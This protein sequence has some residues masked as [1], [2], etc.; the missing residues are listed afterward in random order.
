MCADGSP[1]VLCLICVMVPLCKITLLQKRKYPPDWKL[2]V[3]NV[4]PWPKSEKNW[5]RRNQFFNME[6]CETGFYRPLTD[7][8][9]DVFKKFLC[10]IVRELWCVKLDI[11]VQK[12]RRSQTKLRRNTPLLL[13]WLPRGTLKVFVMSQWGDVT[14]AQISIKDPWIHRI[15]VRIF[16]PL[17]GPH[18][19]FRFLTDTPPASCSGFPE[20]NSQSQLQ[21]PCTT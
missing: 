6:Y 2:L 21:I 15:R 3:R 11:P 13:P 14:S 20:V 7:L 18:R 17:W 12:C 8:H 10:C 5:L 16:C 9:D 1:S 4:E 19:L